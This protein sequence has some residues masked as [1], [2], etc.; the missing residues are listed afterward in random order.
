MEKQDL[1]STKYGNTHNLQL[2]TMRLT[3]KKN[4]KG[5]LYILPE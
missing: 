4:K 5:R 1:D 2:L 3:V